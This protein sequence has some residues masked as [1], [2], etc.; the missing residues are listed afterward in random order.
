MYLCLYCYAR[1]HA[2][3][4]DHM[5][6]LIPLFFV[7]SCTTAVYNIITGGPKFEPLFRDADADEEDWNE[8]NDINK[9]IIRHQIRTEYRVAFPHLYNSRYVSYKIHCIL[10]N[11]S[12]SVV[13]C[14]VMY[15]LHCTHCKHGLQAWCAGSYTAVACTV[16][17]AA[18]S[19]VM[20]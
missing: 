4:D 1:M 14:L 17:A 7:A 9:I 10:H 20:Q 8:F 3:T 16:G 11:R 19:C 2:R 13:K 15:C 5:L 6:V 12:T 18:V